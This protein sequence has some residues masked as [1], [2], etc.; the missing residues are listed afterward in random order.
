MLR[1]ELAERLEGNERM[2]VDDGEVGEVAEH[3]E[4]LVLGGKIQDRKALAVAGENAASLKLPGLLPLLHLLPDLGPKATNI[5]W[6]D[7]A[8][9]SSEAHVKS[10]P[11]S[12]YARPHWAERPM[13]AKPIVARLDDVALRASAQRW[14]APP[15]RG[16]QSGEIRTDLTLE[17]M[18][19]MVAAI[20]KI[21]GDA[22][23][24]EWILRA[25]LDALRPA[26]TADQET[27]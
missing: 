5:Y 26:K 12:L 4:G 11:I 17:Q 1:E 23:Y 9:K 21:P 13:V 8:L 20:A 10:H 15:P 19:D 14:P 22:G 6:I 18:L 27:G 16:Q 7:V 3:L 24:R 2:G 25:A